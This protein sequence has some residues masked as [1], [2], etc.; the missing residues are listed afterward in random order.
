MLKSSCCKEEQFWNIWPMFVT[1]AVLKLLTFSCC[2]EVQPENI[3]CMLNTLPVLKLPRSSCCKAEQPKNMRPMCT[4]LPVF[5][6]SRPEKEVR[7]LKPLNQCAVSFGA[8]SSRNTTVSTDPRTSYHGRSASEV[9][10]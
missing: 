3:W 6:L 8:I 10:V 1:L 7:L 2:K 9:S 5:S 4:T